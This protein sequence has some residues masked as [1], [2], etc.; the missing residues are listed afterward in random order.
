MLFKEK[1]FF[2]YFIFF[3]FHISSLSRIFSSHNFGVY[4]NEKRYLNNVCVNC[5]SIWLLRISFI[6]FEFIWFY[7]FFLFYF[8]YGLIHNSWILLLFCSEL[9][10]WLVG[11]CLLLLLFVVIIA[12]K[13][14][15]SNAKCEVMLSGGRIYL[16][17]SYHRISSIYPNAFKLV[18]KRFFVSSSPYFVLNFITF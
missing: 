3:K 17:H 14:K 18:C 15:C 9:V 2:F 11:W 6:S 1:F 16:Y 13:M 10:G 12:S 8:A 5:V 7:W 4:S